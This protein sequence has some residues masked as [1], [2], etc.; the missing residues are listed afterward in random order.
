MHLST[1]RAFALPVVLIT[2]V[3]MLMVLL[4]GLSAVSS[5][6]AGIRNQYVDQIAQTAADAGAAMAKACMNQNG[7][8]ITW[9]NA[10]PLKPNTNCN[11]TPTT[12]CTITSTDD[13]C[14]VLRNNAYRSTFVVE[15]EVDAVER[16]VVA[17]VKGTARV[18]RTTSSAVAYQ[19]D[20]SLKRATSGVLF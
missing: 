16:P 15:V 6:S 10:T 9:S 19:T 5:V 12:T 1:P 3:I 17:K 11:G 20:V 13:A 18:L 14:Y 2:S 4:F 7:G 8:A